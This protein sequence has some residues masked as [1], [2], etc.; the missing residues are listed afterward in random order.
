MRFRGFSRQPFVVRALSRAD[1]PRAKARTTNRFAFTLIEL[2]VVIAIIALLIALLVPAVQKVRE[3]AA[4]TTCTNNLKQIGLAT[5]TYENTYKNLPGV[6]YTF[7]AHNADPSKSN[8][9]NQAWRTVY[10]DLL[11]FLDQGPVYTAGSSANPIIKGYGW[12]YIS[13]FVAV[14]VIPTY[15][16]PSDA[17][18]GDHLDPT[19]GYTGS[20]LG[21]APMGKNSP[22]ATCNYRA[23]L[24]VFDP[25]VNRSLT[26][27]MPDGTSNTIIHAHCL[28]KCDGSNVGWGPQ[29]IDWGANPGDTGTQHPLPGFGWPTYAAN[30]PIRGGAS[31]N[32]A[33]VPAPAIAGATTGSAANGNQIGV[34]VF[35]YPDFAA[36]NLPF[37]INPAVGNC[38]PDVLASPHDGVMLVTLGDGSVRVVSSSITTATWRSACH[39]SDGIPLG[40]DW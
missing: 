28:Q 11:P 17:T 26:K 39:P 32:Y 20:N 33:G 27:S 37:Q 18:N 40:S 5:H 8:T 7:R 3:A 4:R 21:T 22:Y 35:G 38:R 31:N 14:V 29:Y 1:R 24:M 12:T 10:I 15:L 2:L 34:Y 9:D 19:F 13:N 36:G 25:N 16:C 6:W 30:N 23:N